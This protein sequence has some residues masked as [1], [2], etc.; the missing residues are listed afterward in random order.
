MGIKNLEEFQL[1]QL[2]TQLFELVVAITDRSPALRDGKYCDQIR[3]AARSVCSNLAE[4]YGRYSPA[5]FSRFITIAL[6]SLKEVRSLLHEA[7]LRRFATD[8]EVSRGLD[9]ARRI[10]SG[11]ASM[12]TYLK[13]AR[14]S[15]ARR[16]ARSENQEP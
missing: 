3:D 5:E 16:Q 1:W 13:F 8:E 12:K 9:L 15:Q 6:G 7:R 10:K 2:A 14:P 4:G 11:G